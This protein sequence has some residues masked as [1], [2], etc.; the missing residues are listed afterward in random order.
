MA[1]SKSAKIQTEIEKVKE[2]IN[3][4]QNRLRE[5]ERSKT[6]AENSEIVDIVRGMSVP[7]DDLPVLLQKL[8][9]GEPLGQSVPKSA[10]P[11]SAPAL[12]KEDDTE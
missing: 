10:A 3:G 4:Q 1:T 5:L 2:K 9:A 7:L 8:R 12:E 6:E 11:I